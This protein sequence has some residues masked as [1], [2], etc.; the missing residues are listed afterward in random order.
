[1]PTSK[2]GIARDCCSSVVLFI[3]YDNEKGVIWKGKVAAA[4]SGR[5]HPMVGPQA[6]FKGRNK[7]CRFNNFWSSRGSSLPVLRWIAQNVYFSRVSGYGAGS[8]T[9]SSQQQYKPF[10]SANV[11]LSEIYMWVAWIL[12]Y[13][14]V[15]HV[16]NSISASEGVALAYSILHALEIWS[17]HNERNE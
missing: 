9:S 3:I 2:K 8:R 4:C 13:N 11:T 7:K 10:L 1:M 12:W 5:S 6:D 17:S 14:S 16:D 15:I